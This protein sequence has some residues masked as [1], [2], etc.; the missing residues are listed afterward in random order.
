MDAVNDIVRMNVLSSMRTNHSF[1]DLLL[2]SLLL[3]FFSYIISKI[4]TLETDVNLYTIGDKFNSLFYKKNVLML[5]GK[6]NTFHVFGSTVVTCTF[7]DRFKSVWEDIIANIYNNTTVNEVL[8]LNSSLDTD[9]KEKNQDSTI[10]IVS[11]KRK[12]LYNKKLEIYGIAT[13]FLDKDPPK[14]KSEKNE[15][16]TNAKTD[17]ITIQLYSY[18]TS[19]TDMIA[20]IDTITEKY[21][22]SIETSRKKQKFIYSIAKTTYEE[23]PYECWR[24][25]PFESTRTFNNIF[26]PGKEELMNK[27]EFFITNKKWY[28]DMGIPYSLGIGL[29]G[30]P[31]TGKTSLIKCIAN[32]T[33]RHIVVI[34]LKMIKSRNKLFELFFEDR[35]NKHNKP[36]SM[37]FNKKII[38]FEDIDCAGDVVKKRVMT[39]EPVKTE[40]RIGLEDVVSQLIDI[41]KNKNED[42]NGNFFMSKPVDDPITLDDILNIWDGI[43]ETPGRIMIISSNHYDKLDPALVRPG[44]IDITLEMKN[45]SHEIISQMFQKYYTKPINKTLLKTITNDFYSP[46]EIINIYLAHKNDPAKFMERLMANKK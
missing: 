41:K 2:S 27:L 5:E 35:Y 28:Y 42:K 46:A 30:P 23:H 37:D 40:E 11:Q 15:N 26:F 14:Q 7:T 12:F 16:S 1:I 39:S 21:I 17:R 18:K 25:F 19:L 24:E 4:S 20:H 43:Q 38:V 8:E 31:G 22:G 3:T 9:N 10:F 33:N 34:S 36:H 6:R 45:A 13:V 29:H 32:M 44:R